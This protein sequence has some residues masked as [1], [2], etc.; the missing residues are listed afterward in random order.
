MKRLLGGL[1]VSGVVG[2]DLSVARLEDNASFKRSENDEV[3]GVVGSGQTTDDDRIG[4]QGRTQLR[5]LNLVSTRVT[6]AGGAKLQ[7]ALPN[8]EIS[9]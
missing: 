4:L 8:C 5:E 9:H 3:V 6:S 2:C 1:L 7:N